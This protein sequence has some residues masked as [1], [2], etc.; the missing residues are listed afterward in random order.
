MSILPKL[1]A[2]ASLGH[3]AYGNWVS[4]Q[5]LVRI[6]GLAGLA[7]GLAIVLSIMVSAMLVGCLY[8]VYF[9]L[10]QVGTEQ[11]WAMLITGIS[12]LVVIVALVLLLLV[13]LRRL[14][15][16]PGTLLNQPPITARAMD[17]VD[18]FMNGLMEP[19]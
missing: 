16:M 9:A 7:A 14:R 13:C 18:A 17:T 1:L 3:A 6:I 5:L 4:Q 11:H 2:I 8:G 10:I 12:T 19:R 15:R